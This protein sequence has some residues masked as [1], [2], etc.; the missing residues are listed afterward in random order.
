M[1]GNPF[2]ERVRPFGRNATSEIDIDQ[3]RSVTTSANTN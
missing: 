3:D 2:A 1:G